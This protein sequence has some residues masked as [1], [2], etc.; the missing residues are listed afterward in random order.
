MGLCYKHNQNEIMAWRNSYSH[1][2]TLR[3]IYSSMWQKHILPRPAMN[4]AVN[5]P[6]LKKLDIT[7]HVLSSQLSGLSDVISNW[8]W[9][10]QQNANPTSET[11]GRCVKIVVLSSF[12]HPLCSV[13]KKMMIHVLLRRIVYANT[14]ARYWCLYP[15]LLRNSGHKH[16]HNLLVNASALH[17]SGAY[18]I[19]ICIQLRTRI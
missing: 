19:F 16:K 11:R 9:H 17:Y 13:R 12:K 15:S 5:K 10:H 1:G 8:L 14:R 2:F 18:I 4:T 7:F 6:L 3:C